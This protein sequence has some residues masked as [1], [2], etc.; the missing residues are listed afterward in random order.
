MTTAYP[1]QHRKSNYHKVFEAAL[2]LSA[3]EQRRLRE[4]LAKLAEVRLVSPD[5]SEKAIQYGQRMAAE[6]RA[7]FAQ[8][9]TSTLDETMQQLRGR[10]WS[11]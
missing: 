4:E 5:N 10:A 1:T 7:Q 3:N 6:I 11:S 8:T 2:R 9:D